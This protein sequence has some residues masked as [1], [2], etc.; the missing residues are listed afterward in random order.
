MNVEFPGKL[1]CPGNFLFDLLVVDILEFM[2]NNLGFVLGAEGDIL[3]CFT[4][5]FLV[6]KEQETV[7]NAFHYLRVAGRP[8]LYVYTGP[9]MD[10]HEFQHLRGLIGS[11]RIQVEKFTPDFLSYL[12]AADLSISMAGYNTT[13]NILA[14]HV[15]ALVWPFAANR[16]QRLRAERLADQGAL[17]LINDKDLNPDNLAGRMGQALTRSDFRKAEI[18]LD[19]AAFTARWLGGWINRNLKNP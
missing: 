17:E 1:V 18:D 10:E 5:R 12:A 2:G 14:T 7:I 11:K 13:M 4:D 16:E 8:Y 15:P 3:G 6:G 19:G 9:Y